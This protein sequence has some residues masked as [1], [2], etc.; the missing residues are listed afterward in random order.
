MGG[1]AEEVGSEGLAGLRL[2]NHYRTGDRDPAAE[3]YRPCLSAATD[4]SRAVG[5]FRS[6]IFLIVGRALVDF[7]RRGGVMRLICSPSITD[8]DAKAIDSGYAQRN[9]VVAKAISDDIDAML[10]SELTAYRATVLATLVKVG[11]LDIRLAVRSGAVGIY[12][13]KLGIFRDAWGKR[14]SFIGSANETWSAW[15]H[16]GNHESIEVFCDWK[17]ESEAARVTDHAVH[18][19]RLWNSE[20]PG[21][22]TISF[23]EAQR[24]RLVDLAL[25]DL[26][27]VEKD[28]IAEVSSKRRPL[29]HQTAAIE[30][31][32]RAGRRGIFEHATGSGKTFT[33][34]VAVR[35]HVS[36]GWPALI[37][38][39]S[40]LLLEQW[41]VEVRE[42]LP[43]A[44]LLLAGAGHDSWKAAGRLHAMTG[45][46]SATPRVVIATMQTAATDP[47]LRSVDEG[48]HLLFVADEVHQIGSAFNSRSLA[49]RSGATLGLSATPN[50]Y[51]DPDGTARIFDRFGSVIEPRITLQDAINAGR[52]V[53]YEYYP[54][55]VHLNAGEADAWRKL[56]ERIKK[57][58]AKRF[59]DLSHVRSMGEL[60]KL[61]LIQRSRLAKKAQAKPGLAA[62]IL[63]KHYER[64]QRWLVYCEDSDQLHEVTEALRS[65]GVHPIE[66]HSA[67]A[68]DRIAAMD[69]FRQFGGVIVSIR[70]LDEGVDIPD[71]SH[72]LILASSQNPRQFI[73]RRGRVLRKAH[74]KNIAVVHDAIVVPLD[75]VTEPEQT[76]LLRAEMVRALE[77]AN[78]AINRTAGAQLRVLATSLGIDLETDGNVGVEEDEE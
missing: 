19:E 3:F 31:W 75:L 77:F 38:V 4:Y 46:L 2:A 66:Y 12:H 54:H 30:A 28:R 22:Q 73:Q 69:W 53:E 45:T 42:E 15:H 51:G 52:L 34:L 61:L 6:T 68:G 49:I 43:E 58:A 71:V 32:E 50:R 63:K 7:A 60:E 5:Y 67:M 20:V 29:P 37:L 24:C 10:S 36:Q 9:D 78:A 57:E 25:A 62:S 48:E 8:E 1:S 40:Q 72:A 26:D 17:D 41:A 21:L 16:E 44:V 74:N 56:T 59:G 13:E 11:A 64:G 33:A 14:V 55:V 70:C 35:R 76:S 27:R 23:P 39:P 47:F 18:F 65:V